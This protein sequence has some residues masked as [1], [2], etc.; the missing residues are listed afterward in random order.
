MI[1]AAGRAAAKPAARASEPSSSGWLKEP[2]EGLTG[3]LNRR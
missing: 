1:L 3:A 2:D